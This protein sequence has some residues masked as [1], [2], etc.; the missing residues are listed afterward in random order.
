[1]PLE[2]L[3]NLPV[4]RCARYKIL[5]EEILNETPPGHVDYEELPKCIQLVD[6]ICEAINE[7]V[8]FFFCLI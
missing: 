2:D 4:Q 6:E 3:L 5:I 8:I 7:A 1:M